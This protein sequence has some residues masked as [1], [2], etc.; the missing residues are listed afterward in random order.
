[1]FY[2]AWIFLTSILI[3]RLAP[4]AINNGVQRIVNSWKKPA[5]AELF[6]IPDDWTRDVLPVPCHSHNDYWRAVPLYSALAAGCI[7]VEADVWLGRGPDNSLADDL[8]VGH[9]MKSLRGDWTLE[10]L[11]INPLMRILEHQNMK[12]PAGNSVGVFDRVP[13]TTLVLLIDFK[14]D[15]K[16]TWLFV[17]KQLQPLRERGWSVHWNSTT[18]SRTQAPIIVVSTGN[19]MLESVEQSLTKDIFFDAPLERLSSTDAYT[20]ENSYF[21][22]AAVGK[23]IGKVNR[24][25]NE[26]QVDIVRQ[27][28]DLARSKG[29]VSRYWDTPEWPI[30]ARDRV[31]EVL[32]EQGVGL[33]NVDSLETA[34]RWNWRWCVVAGL[35][36]CA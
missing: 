8:F 18:Q 28:I 7:S 26:K 27:Q 35:N 5:D 10:S 4:L 30:S 2:S 6:G 24:N 11:Y 16:E 23:A 25:L 3:Y 1:M 9:N 32:V 13:S 34:T 14:T 33:L 29:L 22:S 31:W 17:H 36:L 20:A 12:S 19:A 21:A 15:G